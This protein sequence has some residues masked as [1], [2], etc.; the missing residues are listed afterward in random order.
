MKD[1]RDERIAAPLPIA[2]NA[3]DLVK[4]SLEAHRERLD[5]APRFLPVLSC[6]RLSCG[7]GVVLLPRYDSPHSAS[8]ILHLSDSARYEVNVTVENRL[9]CD[10]A[11]AN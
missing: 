8:R 1:R 3:G 11:D 9:P 4:R 10:L 2:G 5:G 6:V 7:G